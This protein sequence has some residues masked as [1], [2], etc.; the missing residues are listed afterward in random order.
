MYLYGIE[1]IIKLDNIG[2]IIVLIVP[3]WNWNLVYKDRVKQRRT[4]LIVPLWNW[5]MIDD[6]NFRSQFEGSN[7]TFMEL[8]WQNVSKFASS[9]IVLI[10]PLWNWNWWKKS[11]VI[12]CHPVLIVPLWNWN[13]SEFLG[14]CG[15]KPF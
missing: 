13:I 5:N 6:S 9:S 1:I 2:E 7:C 4:V 11:L 8:K 14:F 3:L 12:S 15:I 10:V